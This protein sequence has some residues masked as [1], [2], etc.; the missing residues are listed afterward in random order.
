V[1]KAPVSA[2]AVAFAP[3][4]LVRTGRRVVREVVEAEEKARAIVA[5]AQDRAQALVEAAARAAGDVRLRAEAEGRAD[6]VAKVAARALELSAYEARA[7]ERALD[8]TVEVARI[9]AERLLGESLRLDPAVIVALARQA[10]REARGARRVRIVA[11]PADAARLE[12]ELATLGAGFDSLEIA[13]DA[14]R[15]PGDLRLETEIGVLDGALA[16]QL[17][18][19]AKRLRES[20]GK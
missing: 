8:R 14:A 9:L 12:A 20:M 19:L 2:R 18:R 7:D 17:D 6:G 11:H 5:E 15:T 1:L 10:L 13:A 3:T 16:P 4:A